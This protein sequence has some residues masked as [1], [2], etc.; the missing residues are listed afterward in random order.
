MKQPFSAAARGCCSVLGEAALFLLLLVPPGDSASLREI[1]NFGDNPGNLKMFL[2]V[3]D[4]VKPHPAILVGLHWCHGT[5]QAYYNGNQYRSLADKYGFVVIYP[6]CYSSDSCFDVHSQEALTHNGGSD[7]LGIISMIRYVIKNNN[8]D[9]TRVFVTGHSGGGMMTNVMAGSYPGVF[10]AASGS[11]TVPFACFAGG[12]SPDGWNDDCARGKVTKT[13]QEWGDLVRKAYPG[14]SGPRPRMQLWHGANDDILY[15]VNFQEAIEQW[16]NVLGVSQT[17]STTESNK[18]LASYTRTRYTDNSGTV[19]VEAIKGLNQSH[20]ITISEAEVVAFFGLDKTVEV[21]GNDS[22]RIS[23][24]QLSGTSLA[25][26]RTAPGIYCFTLA[27]PPGRIAIDLYDL[28]GANVAT[29]AETYS[30]N[31][32]AEIVW[33]GS[34]PDRASFPAAACILLIKVNGSSAGA[35]CR[36]LFPGK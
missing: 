24:Y 15:P 19:M 29:I 25:L 26:R 4:N 22:R 10:N 8:G 7:P 21:D 34:T 27:S 30:T 36:A 14:Y 5:A 32:N 28:N 13:P 6:G 20:N 18:P 16:T 12:T 31:G 1:T 33:D 23:R 35:C 11:A 17:P 9:S 3:P 2:Y